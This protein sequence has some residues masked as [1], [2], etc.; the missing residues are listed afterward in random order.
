MKKFTKIIASIGPASEDPKILKAMLAAGVDGCRLNF[1]HDTGAVQGKKFDL[2]RKLSNQ[3]GRPIAIIADLQGPKHRIGN[4]ETEDHYPLKIG[5]KF[6]LDSDPNPGDGTRVF[7]PD[8]DVLKALKVGDRVLLNDGKIELEVI[9]KNQSQVETIVKHGDEIWSRRGFN[10]P[11]T[12]IETGVLTDKDRVD[13]EYAIGKGF[14]FVAASFVQ[15]A[16]DIQ[17]IRDFI[18][19]RTAAPIKIIAKIERPQA[20]QNMEDIIRISDAIMFARGDLA[21]EVP[22][23]HLP[24]LQR[25]WLRACRQMNKP[26]IVAT[27]VLG[28]MVHSEMPLRAEISD[29]ATVSYLRADCVMTSE[30]TTISD[31]PVNV[32]ETMAKILSYAD[33]DAAEN[34][35]DLTPA[36]NLS[37]NDWSQSVAAM[38]Q[39]NHAAAIVV[40]DSGTEITT[41]ISCRK[42]DIPIIAV[43]N[44][45]I[46]ANQLCLSRGVFPI[47]AQEMFGNRDATAAAN[48]FGIS[49]G[50]LVVVDEQDISLVS[51]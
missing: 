1:S 21:V 43:V 33:Q 5:Q 16:N 17:E 35:G 45:E 9:E 19:A 49:R 42:P 48:Q 51:L 39:L 29:A 23:E 44:D 46:E 26:F 13:L 4:F 25:K 27:Q 2:I 22:F 10:I 12:E 8:S 36:Q 37:E 30:E 32:I 18:N 31:E 3:L 6:I 11:D 14:D 50:K 41:Q 15:N 24:A 20:L 28:S 40:F 47:F 38:A 7:L 34:G